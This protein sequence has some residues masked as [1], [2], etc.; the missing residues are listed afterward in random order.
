MVCHASKLKIGLSSLAARHVRI[1]VGGRPCE[2]LSGSSG[3]SGALC[4]VPPRQVT[5]VSSLVVVVDGQ[6]SGHVPF[7]YS[8]PQV[9]TNMDTC[10]IIDC[11]LACAGGR[12]KVC[13][14]SRLCVR[15]CHVVSHLSLS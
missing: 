14:P 2:V 11:V 1:L 4:R 12:A 5:G 15:L 8:N 9:L 10:H 7:T 13:R 3:Q 6:A